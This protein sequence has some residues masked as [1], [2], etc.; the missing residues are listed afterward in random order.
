MPVKLYYYRYKECPNRAHYKRIL[1]CAREYYHRNKNKHKEIEVHK[2][3]KGKIDRTCYKV[4][5]VHERV[6][7]RDADGRVLITD[8]PSQPSL[9]SLPSLP[10]LGV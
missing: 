6:L 5:P 8:Q 3:P 1:K 10:S 7:P 4:P 2:M 9:A